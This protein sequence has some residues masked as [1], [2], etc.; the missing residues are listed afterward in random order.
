M[1]GGLLGGLAV[2]KPARDASPTRDALLHELRA[3]LA[4]ADGLPSAVVML[5]PAFVAGLT[6]DQARGFLV[7]ALGMCYKIL[8]TA[9]E[10][11]VDSDA[12]LIAANAWADGA[13][14]G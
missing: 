5:A 2:P 12:I 4:T 9:G 10:A 7:G 1:L 14:G 3:A 8:D 11:G 13:R 6:D